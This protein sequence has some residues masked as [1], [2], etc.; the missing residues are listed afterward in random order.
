MEEDE[1][2]MRRCLELAALGLGNVQPNPMVGAVIV[3]N[4][5]IIAEGWHRK[6]GEAHAEINALRQVENTEILKHATLYVNLEPCSH[7]GKTP[8]CVD[9]V[10]AA[11][12][13]RVVVGTVDPNPLVG[14]RGVEKLRAHGIEV[15]TPVL[16]DE[17]LELN[18]RFFT[19]HQKHRP[20]II[21]KWAQTRDGFMDVKRDKPGQEYH[22][23]ITNNELRT[24][25]HQWRAEEDALLVGYNTFLNDK[26][27]LTTRDFPGK[28]PI[29][30]ILE[31]DKAKIGEDY[32]DLGNNDETLHNLL[33][34]LWQKNIQSII[35]EGGRKTLD[36]FLQA[37]LCDEMRVLIGNQTWHEGT[38]APALNRQPDSEMSVNDNKVCF[39]R[40]KKKK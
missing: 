28:N 5:R 12:I 31:R 11:R 39:Y 16:E 19:A 26:P 14:G 32:F 30:I 36:R 10:L 34:I 6:F 20:Y 8:P 29:P 17:C 13:P 9:A 3:A 27:Q 22:Y 33:H 40:I 24:L 1:I 2:F 21:L 23:W 25:V 18:R 38:P 37:D 35:V 15:R 7:F 4:G